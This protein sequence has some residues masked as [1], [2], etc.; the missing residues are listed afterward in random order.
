MCCGIIGVLATGEANVARVIRESLKRLEYRG[1]DS[2]G[3]ATKYNGKLYIKKDKGKIDDI[4]RKLNLDVLPGG[5]GIGHT[6]WATHGEPSRVNSHPHTDCKNNIAVVHNGIIENFLELREQLIG[7]GHRFR[8]QTD[9]EVIPHLI[10]SFMENGESIESAV[11]STLT[12]LQ[13]A[14]ALAIIEIKSNRIICVRKESPLVLGIGNSALYCASDIP[15]FLPMTNQVLF[16]NDGD[17]VILEKGELKI[18]RIRGQDGSIQIRNP[19][20]IDWTPEM[21]Q[22]GGMPHFMLKEIHEQPKAVQN[23]LRIRP[24]EIEKLAKLLNEAGQIILTA[25]GTSYHACLY[26]GY[27]F[28]DLNRINTQQVI[29]SEFAE[30]FGK[31]LNEDAVILSVSQS[32]ETSDT[33][34]AIQYAKEY[35]AKICAITNVVGSS[36]TRTSDHFMYTL[37]GPEI[38]VAATKT[39]LVQITALALVNLAVANMRGTL[40]SSEIKNIHENLSKIP[41]HISQIIEK[42]EDYI[43]VTADSLANKQNFLFLGKGINTPTALEGALKLKEISYIHAEAYPAGESKHGPIALVEPD[44]PVVFVAPS[45]S[46]MDR[47]VGNIMEMKARGACIIGVTDNEKIHNLSDYTFWIPKNIPDVLTPLPS[48]IPL[49]LFSYYAAIKRNHDPDKPRN[50]AKS[51]T[52]L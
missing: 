29:S 12:K 51:V 21:A 42:Y 26:G 39:F 8:S 25:A 28:T 33:L 18:N 17:F 19:V 31:T 7:E 41:K 11:Q 40:D 52:V 48:T 5:I 36:V 46:T 34:S 45:D 37:A 49:Q 23:T 43:K 24:E 3:I 35:N 1:Y 27:L 50:L 32:G 30:K 14:Y 47:I 2:V 4:H 10:E 16:V 9:T 20:M 15:A 6:R 38:G 13:G 44:F 22:K